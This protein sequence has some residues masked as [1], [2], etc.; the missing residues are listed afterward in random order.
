MIP[1]HG[2]TF[3]YFSGFPE[4][5]FPGFPFSRIFSTF[6]RKSKKAIFEK[7]VFFEAPLKIDGFTMVFNAF[8]NTE[9]H[10]AP[11]VLI[12]FEGDVKKVTF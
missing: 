3:F 11:L 1:T 5:I 6:G 10:V 7:V 4:N 12:G 8:C 2:S 9:N